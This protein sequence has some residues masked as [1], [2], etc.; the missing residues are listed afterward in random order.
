MDTPGMEKAPVWVEPPRIPA[1]ILE[2]SFFEAQ[3]QG[4]PAGGITD[5]R[6]VY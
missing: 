3:L 4:H 6:V 5:T 1:A 2:A